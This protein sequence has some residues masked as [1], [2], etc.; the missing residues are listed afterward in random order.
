MGGLSAVGSIR[1]WC[2]TDVYSATIGIRSPQRRPPTIIPVCGYWVGM[3]PGCS[4]RCSP[5]HRCVACLR[6]FE[7]RSRPLTP[8]SQAARGR[9]HLLACSAP[10]Q[11]DCPVRRIWR[12]LLPDFGYLAHC[13]RGSPPAILKSTNGPHK[14]CAWDCVQLIERGRHCPVAGEAMRKTGLHREPW[15]WVT[16]KVGKPKYHFCQQLSP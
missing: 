9:M 3:A 10:D 8:D 15:A 6:A 1:I 11:R 7:I 5:H 12:A 14:R 16:R 13:G 2:V 4:W